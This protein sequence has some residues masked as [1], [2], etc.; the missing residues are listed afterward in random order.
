[1][2]KTI[3]K[4]LCELAGNDDYNNIHYIKVIMFR[5]SYTRYLTE[6][7]RILD[8]SEFKDKIIEE[9]LKTHEKINNLIESFNKDTDYKLKMMFEDRNNYCDRE[10]CGACEP[11]GMISCVNIQK[12]IQSDSTDFDSFALIRIINIIND[13][14]I[15]FIDLKLT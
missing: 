10:T 12:Y 5:A 3:D 13:E 9:I 7:M 11:G 1:M 6:A 4:H 8:N 15:N 14:L 2:S